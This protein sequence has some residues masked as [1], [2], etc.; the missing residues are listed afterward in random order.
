MQSGR[1][2]SDPLVLL[3]ADQAERQSVHYD[4]ANVTVEEFM[5]E[6]SEIVY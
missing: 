4:V 6:Q 5:D 1:S 3:F 2:L